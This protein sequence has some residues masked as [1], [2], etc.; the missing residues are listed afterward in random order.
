MFLH[1]FDMRVQYDAMNMTELTDAEPKDNSHH[2]CNKPFNDT[3]I[4]SRTD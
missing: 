2:V 3:S 4:H 1:A